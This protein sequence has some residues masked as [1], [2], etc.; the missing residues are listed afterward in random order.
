MNTWQDIMVFCTACQSW[1]PSGGATTA[2]DFKGDSP[3]IT[4][5][6]PFVLPC[7][8]RVIADADNV[9]LGADIKY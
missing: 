2:V 6:G 1:R 8:H 4:G 9:R 3:A 5:T 7:G